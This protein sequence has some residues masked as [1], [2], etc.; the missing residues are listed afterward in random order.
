MTDQNEVELG[1]FSVSNAWDLLMESL[2]DMFQGFVQHLPNLLIA[3]VVLV[4]GWALSWAAQKAYWRLVRDRRLRRSLKDLFAKLISITVW[5]LALLAASVVVFPSVKPESIL[6]G[7]GL[8]SIAIG[9]AFKDV[10]ENFFAGFLILIRE[11]L[12]IGDFIKCDNVEG[13][14]E[15]ITIRDTLI[16]QTDGQRVVVPNGMLFKNP[17]W[18]RTDQEERRVSVICGVAYDVDL[19]EAQG[20]IQKALEG[21]DSIVG[22]REVEVYAHEFGSS[23]IDFEV[24]WWTGSKPGEIRRSK[25]EVVRA[26]KAALDDAGIEIP[27]PY[28]TL[29][30]KEPLSVEQGGEREP[31]EE[32][33]E[34]A[35]AADSA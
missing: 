4:L 5:T 24:T 19:E 22:S 26:I 33:A 6:A 1:D 16:R 31:S 29:T 32:T 28:R 7:L 25:D 3:L 8:S 10:V 2:L 18:I 11:P 27:F 21:L 30:F 34:T 17:V 23:S 14:V 15:T 13:K 35:E 20:V 9:F 12:E